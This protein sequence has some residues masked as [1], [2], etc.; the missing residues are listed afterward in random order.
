MLQL[1]APRVLTF[2]SHLKKKK[3]THTKCTHLY[4]STVGDTF[5]TGSNPTESACSPPSKSKAV[6]FHALKLELQSFLTS[7]TGG[8]D[9]SASRCNR[10]TPGK[11]PPGSH[12]LEGCVETRTGLESL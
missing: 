5:V 6:L 7:V 11:A 2:S 10:F 8:G 12:W 1:F 9:W 3:N 4:S